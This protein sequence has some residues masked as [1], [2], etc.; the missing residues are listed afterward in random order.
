MNNNLII[1]IMTGNENWIWINRQLIFMNKEWNGFRLNDLRSKK[2][3]N[4]KKKEIC[5]I[6]KLSIIGIIDSNF[7]NYYRFI[8]MVLRHCI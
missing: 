1:S 2:E 8:M 4:W 7:I 3:L 6:I 5:E